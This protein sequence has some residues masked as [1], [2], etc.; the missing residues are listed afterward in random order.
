MVPRMT[1][2]RTA[3]RLALTAALALGSATLSACGGGGDSK[4]TSTP[5]VDTAAG[6]PIVPRTPS[7]PPDART[8]ATTTTRTT[9]ATSPTP[10]AT[11]APLAA[12][13]RP[14]SA[15][16]PWNTRVDTMDVERRSATLIQTATQRLGVRES[17]NQDAVRT[18]QRRINAPLFINTK[19]WTDPVVDAQDDGVPTKVVCRQINLP[20]PDNDCGDGWSV[21]SLDIPADESPRPQ[22]DGWFTVVDR[23][24][25]VAY[26]LWRARRSADGRS[27]SYQFMRRW[28]LRGPGFLPPGAVSARGSGLPLFAGLITPADVRSGVIRHALA[29][30]VPGPAARNYV[31]PASVTDGNGP[32]GSLP[33]G[34]R[35]RLKP[36]VSFD[37]LLST[38][39]GLAS[40][41]PT[42]DGT[43]SLRR[44]PF[45]G[46]TNRRAARAILTALRDY[47]AIVVDRAATPT[48]YA[49]LN[50]K[51]TTPLRRADGALLQADGRHLVGRRERAR[52]GAG[53]PLLRG[54]E[55]QGLLLTDFEVVALPPLRR[56]PAPVS[57]AADGAT[58]GLDGVQPQ[59]TTTTSSDATP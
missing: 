58:S 4:S 36:G 16:S 40:G 47:G 34:A 43:R 12:G 44:R 52:P 45:P 48:L 21:S 57:S 5:G 55:V 6:A 28:D 26:D 15:R 20:P 22:Y 29:I 46:N 14:F 49:Q 9:T 38:N 10:A 3:T 2:S 35:I 1:L 54:S 37:R 41:V 27:M 17:G 25:G 33:E 19:V 18:E 59:A 8:T 50:V 30:A 53:T 56:D 11:G 31:Q 42:A 24:K 23:A 13:A 7:L 39:P 32:F 51:W